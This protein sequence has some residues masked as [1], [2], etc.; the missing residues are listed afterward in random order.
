[1]IVR[2]AV[3]TIIAVAVM[4]ASAGVVV[5]SA[6]YAIYTLLRIYLGPAGAGAVIAGV[7]AL[8]L[9][10]V[11][12]IVLK[13]GKAPKAAPP[14]RSSVVA[15]V[16]DTLTERPVMAA[17]AAAAAGLIAWRN[18]RL[19]S[20]VLAALDQRSDRAASLRD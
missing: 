6:S 1:M 18:P 19:V 12:V 17:G 16:L 8:L 2:R 9:A 3:Q 5:V 7:F 15:R 13:G 11:G 4:A 10:I 14:P 20:I